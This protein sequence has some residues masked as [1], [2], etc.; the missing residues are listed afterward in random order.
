MYKCP[1]CENE[2]NQATEV[3]P[4]CGADLEALAA[5]ALAAEPPKQRSTGKIV[6]IWVT[7]VVVVAVGLYAF[8]WYV[9]PERAGNQSR[10]GVEA[11]VLDSLGEFQ[12][13]L[14]NFARAEGGRYPDS[15]EALGAPGR[16][17]ARNA[18]GV[19]YTLQYT[20]GPADA[21][22]AVR[23]YGLSARPDRYGFRSF[24]TDQSRA[25]HVTSENRPATLQDPVL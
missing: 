24:Y 14:E 21:D 15:A 20:P 7:V 11:R 25:V 6:L 8:I 9:L 5:V 13:T 2:I 23:N 10:A 19:G 1:E 4:H 17:A 18:L 22:G 3:C 12:T 16:L